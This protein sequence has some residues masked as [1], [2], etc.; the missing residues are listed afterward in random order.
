MSKIF[1][2]VAL[3]VL[4]MLSASGIALGQFGSKVAAADTDAG[5]ALAPIALAGYRFFD[6]D[7]GTGYSAADPVYMRSAPP[8]INDRLTPVDAVLPG[9]LVDVFAPDFLISQAAVPLP[10]PAIVYLPIYGNGV[11]YDPADPVYL[12]T[13]TAAVPAG[14]LRANDIRISLGNPNGIPGTKIADF[15]G[16]NNALYTLMPGA[17]GVFY[18]D[19]DQ[20]LS[21]TLGDKVYLHNTAAGPAMVLPGDIRLT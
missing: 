17:W 15:S 6:I 19:V 16:D 3:S 12:V 10:A 9:N 13:N 2:V 4:L 11:A 21:Y 7:T 1:F 18:D 14:H 8:V 5:H 20:T